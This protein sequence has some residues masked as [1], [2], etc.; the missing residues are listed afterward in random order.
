MVHAV[1]EKR[2]LLNRVDR[3]RGQ[4]E[5]IER[6]L[7]VDAGCILIMQLL[8]AARGAIAGLMAEVLK[9]HSRI[10]MIDAEHVPAASEARA[11]NELVSVL[12]SYIR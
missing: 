8:T 10:H 5:A 9:D 12:R 3:L 11:A 1:T 2:K 7:G 4:I 6:A